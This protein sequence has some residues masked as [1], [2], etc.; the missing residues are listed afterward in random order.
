MTVLD[1]ADA[2]RRFVFSSKYADQQTSN[3]F[4][5]SLVW[6]CNV[7]KN[8]KLFLY[9]FQLVIDSLIECFMLSALWHGV[10]RLCIKIKWTLQGRPHRYNPNSTPF[11]IVLN[12]LWL[13]Q[14]FFLAFAALHWFFSSI[15][16]QWPLLHSPF[17]C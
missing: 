9:L 12:Y 15:S 6:K 8:V 14:F 17:S 3:S 1:C 7:K 4:W 5:N 10:L 16:S 13:L 2:K 11:V